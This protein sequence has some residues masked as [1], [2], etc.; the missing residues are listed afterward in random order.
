MKLLLIV[1]SLFC[2]TFQISGQENVLSSGSEGTSSSGKVTYSVGLIHYKEVTGSGGV[3]STGTQ[4]PYEVSQIL[5]VDDFNSSITKVFPNPTESILNI[6]LN[7]IQNLKYQLIDLS[8]RKVTSGELNTLQ[9]K[10]ELTSIETSIYILNIIK[11]NKI[12]ESYKIS[13]K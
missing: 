1:V 8:G 11:E 2:F 5:N 13:K 10:I 6:H 12:I 7:T 9:S 3:S 4:I